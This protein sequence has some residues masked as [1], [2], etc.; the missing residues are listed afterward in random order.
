MSFLPD[1]LRHETLGVMIDTAAPRKMVER[2]KSC[3]AALVSF[4]SSFID[5]DLD[6]KGRAKVSLSCFHETQRFQF[7]LIL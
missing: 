2:V 4:V 1:L 5:E 3:C 6:G 7:G